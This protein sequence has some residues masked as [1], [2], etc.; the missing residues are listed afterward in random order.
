MELFVDEPAKS[1][2]VKPKPIAQLFVRA[3]QGPRTSAT[4]SADCPEFPIVR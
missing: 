3:E 2:C 1:I 4:L